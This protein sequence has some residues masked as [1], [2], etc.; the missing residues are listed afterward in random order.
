[1]RRLTTCIL[2]LTF[3]VAALACGGGGSGS[4]GFD[5]SV[6]SEVIDHVLASGT[7]V[8]R[9]P[10][11]FCPADVGP[12]LGGDRSVD[13]PFDASGAV[14][15]FEAGHDP[16]LCEF[17][18]TFRNQGFPDSTIFKVASRVFGSDRPWRVGLRATRVE[19]NDGQLNAVPAIFDATVDERMQIALLALGTT[20]NT[21]REMV[22]ELEETGADLVF[23]VPQQT[24][25][26]ELPADEDTVI[27][28]VLADQAC[29]KLGG[30]RVCPIGVTLAASDFDVELGVP[31]FRR[32]T[33][34]LTVGAAGAALG[35]RE[36]DGGAAC[37][38]ELMI[39][40]KGLLASF[41]RVAVRVEGD[42]RD[43]PWVVSAPAFAEVTATDSTGPTP[44][45]MV[46]VDA[47]VPLDGG[48]PSGIDSVS[49]QLA[50]LLE[51]SLSPG[52]ERLRR[53]REI[54]GVYVFV[55]R[56]RSVPVAKLDA[57][58]R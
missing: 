23:V 11:A 13:T 51:P 33:E 14:R 5:L 20:A 31:E 15:C 18:F 45:S 35:C 6:E 3:A 40:T 56:P 24:S 55:S 9:G 41:Y 22:A 38:L 44:T 17:A 26:L 19:R 25:M 21:D 34:V 28:G 2:T 1:M 48:E 4:S 29:A 39:E 58:K 12:V 7:C 30:T 42:T 52:V 50:V 43:R 36:L 57:V 47:L 8:Q 32:E 37:R 53:L 27:S 54:A 46:S 10:T 16:N 49:L